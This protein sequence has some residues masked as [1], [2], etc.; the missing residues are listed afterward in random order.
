MSFRVL[1]TEDD[2]VQREI[3][4]DILTQAGYEARGCAS[5]EE[6]LTVLHGYE[7]EILLTD[8][9][10]PGMDGLELLR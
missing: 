1:V 5:A 3:I 6:A 10:M 2:R 8:M 7:A 4:C 9:R